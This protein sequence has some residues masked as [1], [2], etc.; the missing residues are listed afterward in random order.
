MTI[1]EENACLRSE[2]AELRQH[3]ADLT[4]AVQE[5]EAAFEA[6]QGQI[7]EV[8]KSKKEPPSWVKA[9]KPKREGDKKP[10]RKRKA[11][12]NRA[13]RR[14]E[15]TRIVKHELERCPDCNYRL[16]RKKLGHKHQVIDIPPPAPVEVTEHQVN[17][18]WCPCCEKWRS[19]KLDL[20]QV[21]LGQGRIGLRVTSLIVYLRSVMRLSYRQIQ[22]YLQIQH[23][24][25]ISVGEVVGILHRVRKASEGELEAL[26]AA[27]QASAVVYAD[28]TGWRE[29]GQNG[30]IWGFSV[31]GPDAIRYY[32]YNHSRSRWVVKGMLGGKFRGVLVSDFLGSYNIYD[33]PHQ[34]C[35]AHLLRDLHKLKEEHPDEVEVIA[36]AKSVRQLYDEGQEL[37]RATS[38]PAEQE[39][40][41]KYIRLLGRLEELG[42]AH[43]STKGHPCKALAQRL[44][45]H[46]DEMF[47]FVLH[48]EVS[49]D[50]NLAERSL[51]HLVIARK[52]SGGTRS[53]AG[54]ATRMALASLV[55][56]W[57]ARGQNP[58]EECLALLRQI[59]LPQ[60]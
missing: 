55:G 20:R 13:R 38:P 37:V 7:E 26:R 17:K 22:A 59:P 12:H 43:A 1:E 42:Q 16:Y 32:H 29:D 56:T 44:L 5:L 27:M 11:E 3:V 6:A 10:R 14:E 51:R 19:P 35:W 31:P 8:K 18:G 25:E 47:Q 23:R 39:R 28:E 9:N 41:A 58:L 34:R 57:L 24:M 54:S 21:V 2:V 30:Y 60:V 53:D 36:W 46:L 4:E 33:G 52:I 45:R 50:N 48:E 40:Q 49:A 15:P